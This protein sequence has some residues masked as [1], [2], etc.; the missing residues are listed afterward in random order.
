MEA[1]QQAVTFF[2]LLAGYVFTNGINLFW[3]KHQTQVND[4]VS[5]FGS[6]QI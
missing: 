4:Y 3:V 1:W 6:P 5:E 2:F